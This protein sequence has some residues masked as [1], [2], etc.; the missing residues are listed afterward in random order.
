MPMRTVRRRRVVLPESS[1]RPGTVWPRWPGGRIEPRAWLALLPLG[2]VVLGGA[3]ERWSQGVMLLAL[4][5]VLTVTPPRASLG[6]GLNLALGALALLALA[7]FLPARWFFV[8][9]WRSALGEDF[10]TSLPG[11][12]SPQPWR[13]AESLV[14][15]AA[16]LSWFYLM[17]TVRWAEGERQ[18]TAGVFAA[19]VA[20]LAAT[21]VGLYRAGVH[22]ALWPSV[23]GFGPFPNRN[24]TADF[25]AIG[26]LPILACARAAWRAGGKPTALAW[27]AG[28]LVAAMAVFDSFSRAGVA[29]LFATT[30]VYLVLET[31]H[32][33]RHQALG[34]KLVRWRRVAMVGSLV[35]VLGSGLLVFGGDTLA[36]LRSGSAMTDGNTM[37]NALRWEIYRDTANMVARSPWCGN[38]L[39][40]FNEIFATYRRLAVENPLR[41]RHPES[42]WLWLAAELGWPGVIAALAGL[43]LLTRRLRLPRHGAERP[44]RLAAAMGVAGFL[45]HSLVDVSAHRVGSVF[46]ATFLLGLALPGKRS[47]GA[48]A[49][50]EVVRWPSWIFRTAGGLFLAVGSLWLLEARGIL[51]L[52]GE[53][54]VERLKA[55]ALVQCAE[56][57]STGAYRSLTQALAWSPLD[58]RA[59]YLRA[60]I[61]V[62]G[63]R[64]LEATRADFRRAR[65]L[66]EMN[67]A[68]PTNEA[69]LWVS[70]GQMPSAVSALAEACRRDPAHATD[71]LRPVYLA[72]R[73]DAEF[74]AGIGAAARRDPALTVA[75]LQVLE[76]PDTAEFIATVL[77]TDPDLQRLSDRQKT[78]FFQSWAL[79]GE[80]RALAAAM[81]AHPAWQPLGW[82]A[83]ADARA[84]DGQSGSLQAACGIAARF[85]PKP[86]WPTLPASPKRSL[87][88]LRQD[89][90]AG[91]PEP[92]QTLALYAAEKA[93]GDPTGAL[94]ALR[95]ATS[96]PGCPAYFFRLEAEAASELGQWSVA[97]EAWQKYLSASPENG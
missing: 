2:C 46:A 56:R 32:R 10:G 71:Y 34:G 77:S 20:L 11:T 45:A 19:G 13:T 75:L 94:E 28:W 50:P 1:R 83:W 4:G 42:D 95:Q 16:G 70:A 90:A 18:R 23:R 52:P 67:A 17:G 29:L 93:A 22:P 53:Q 79:R 96:R 69:L 26:A 24:Q 78:R 48:E 44:L 97:W 76:A 61:G 88:E 7:A 33:T 64:D 6:R 57:D 14:V 65:Y 54:G 66:E 15:F 63:R 59:Y 27:L 12:L 91:E 37:S 60:A 89:V 51:L 47:E 81:D 84:R 30:F 68:L 87:E 41:V 35:L 92:A 85:A 36:R 62:Y 73:G 38:G 25:F 72:A 49:A 86:E 31:F 82:R 43:A 8:P 74:T 58:W 9:A 80:P 3:T 55:D 40:T 21:A 5:G 39:D